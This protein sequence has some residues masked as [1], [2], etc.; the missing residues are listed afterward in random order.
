M[1]VRVEIPDGAAQAVISTQDKSIQ[2]QVPV[3]Q[4]KRRLNGKKL[5]YFSATMESG[6]ILEIGDRVEHQNW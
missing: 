6:S 2:M 5:G 4:V 3:S 1:I